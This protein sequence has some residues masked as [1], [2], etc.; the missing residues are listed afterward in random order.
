MKYGMRLYFG[1]KSEYQIYEDRGGSYHDGDSDKDREDI[2]WRRA[3][4]E[5]EDLGQYDWPADMRA[6][7]ERLT[8]KTEIQIWHGKTAI[9]LV[10]MIDNNQAFNQPCAFGNLIEGHAVYCHNDSWL[11]APRKC[12]RTWYTGG[13]RRDEDCPG[14][15]PNPQLAKSP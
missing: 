3:Y 9:N 14:Y 11:Y 15:V 13:E 12:R 10:E 4:D 8:G 5:N 6:E 2:V 7:Y 1:E